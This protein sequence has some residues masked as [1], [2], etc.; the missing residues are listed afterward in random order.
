MDKG[1]FVVRNRNGK[2]QRYPL[3]E[4]EIGEVQ[5][6]T[7]N[8]VSS[9]ALA[10]IG[11]WGIDCILLSGRGRPVAV[12]RPL[13]DDSHVKTRIAQYKSLENGKF[14]GIAKQFVLSKIE[15]QN[16]VLSKYG[17]R[18]LDYSHI[19]T[20]KSLEENDTRALRA[21][22]TN[23]ESACSRYYFKQVFEMFSEVVR[24]EGRKGFKAY[25]G[26]NNLFNLA[27]ETLFWKVHIAL[28]KAKLEPFLGYLH[29]LAWSKPSLV[30]DFQELFRYLMDDFVIGYARSLNPKDFVLKTE[31]FS[32][33]RKG[34]REY[35]NDDK[36][37]AFM[38]SLGKYFL[39]EVEIPRIRMGKKQEVETL[40]N[41]EAL[42]FAQY[43]RNEK[44]S[45][46]PRL[47]E[48]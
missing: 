1:C 21:K 42:L 24:P 30:C 13:D 22:L 43:L 7:G 47:A 34:K 27:Y 40:I 9:G 6:R 33:N 45:W 10:S 18:R 26:L 25:D 31:D 36:T 20:V 28:A 38:K 2:E 46:I 5:I 8:T 41:E 4:S 32:S 37:R 29:S 15:G 17:L 12:V 16:K 39:A 14:S 3:F 44:R 19:E 35:L 48:I 11:F 23:I